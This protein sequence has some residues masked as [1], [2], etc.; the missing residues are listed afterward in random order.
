MVWQNKEMR[1]NIV[2]KL[3]SFMVIICLSMSVYAAAVSDNDGSAFISKSEFDSLKNN[4][5]AQLDKF[6]TSI[7]T[8]LDNAIASYLAGV[9]ASIEGILIHADSILE[10]PVTF[11]MDNKKYDWTSWGTNGATPYWSPSLSVY[12]FGRRGAC[13]F[14]IDKSFDIPSVNNTFYNGEWDTR[15]NG[16]KITEML[17]NVKGKLDVKSVFYDK[18][19][20]DFSNHQYITFGFVLD[21]NAQTPRQ[22][23]PGTSTVRQNIRPSGEILEDFYSGCKEYNY[24]LIDSIWSWGGSTALNITSSTTSN[25][26]YL[27]SFG[28]SNLWT[29]SNNPNHRTYSSSL[30]YNATKLNLIMNAYD[31]DRT[32]QT[33]KRI[34]LPVAYKGHIYLTNKN[35]FKKDLQGGVAQNATYWNG[36]A[37]NGSSLAYNETYTTTWRFG[38]MISPG[39]TLEPQFSGFK[40]SDNTDR[41]VNKK[42]LME[43]QDMYYIVKTPY[44]KKEHRQYMTNGILLT[45]ANNDLEWLKVT[46]NLTSEDRNINKYL[47]MSKSPIEEFDYRN[48]VPDAELEPTKY[49]KISENKQLKDS[50]YLYELKEGENTIY[51]GNIK[52]NELVYYKILWIDGGDA[53]TAVINSSPTIV[54]KTTGN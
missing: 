33:G 32:N 48:V 43:P 6:N 26:N 23:W 15:H 35:N 52:K 40:N 34:E 38:N 30:V 1:L 44:S 36:Y 7:D 20:S 8:K 54:G 41:E 2:K 3:I 37:V 13:N 4:F 31:I 47:V 16:Y 51:V 12:I 29:E 42:S 27:N 17:T 45:E 28:G 46:Y 5:Q 49:L 21:Q 19:S 18:I 22:N 24:F 50:V 53:T 25:E 10:Y 39:W 11:Q 14:L 9:K